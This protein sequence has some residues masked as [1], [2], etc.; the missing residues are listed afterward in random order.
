MTTGCE[1]ESCHHDVNYLVRAFVNR[2]TCVSVV[3][4]ALAAGVSPVLAADIRSHPPMR[5]L[6]AAS[7]RP[8]G[9]GPVRF[10]DSRTGDDRNDGSQSR[11][12]R[13]I[14]YAIEHADPGMTVCLRGGTYYEH[15]TLSLQATRQKPVTLRSHP[16]ELAI[17][18]GGLR[19]FAESP[20]SAWEPVPDGAAGEFRSTQTWPDLGGR[21]GSTNLLGNFGDSMIPLHGYRYIEDLRSDN[22]YLSELKSGKSE[23]G[24]GVYC[25]PGLFYDISTGRIHIRLAHTRQTALGESN[26]RGETDPRRLSLIIAGT[27]PGPALT[28]DGSSFIRIQDLVVRG[29]RSATVQVTDSVNVEFDGVTMYGGAAPISVRDTAG[30][31]LWNCACRGIAAPWTF[32]GSLKYR[33]IEARLFSASGWSPTGRDNRNFELAY[34]EFTDCVDGVFIGNVRSV[35]FHHNL[36]DNVSDD[37]IFLTATTAYDGTTHGGD[38]HIYQNLLSR[39]LTTFA[40]GVGHGRQKMTATGRQ[41]GSGVY[42]YRNVFDLREPVHYQQPA[43]GA[44]AVT[45]AGRIAGDHGSPL[46]EPMRVYHNTILLREPPYRSYYGGGLGGHLA[47]GSTRRVFNNMFV[48]LQGRPG[49]VLPPVIPVSAAR[50]QSGE[51][52]DQNAPRKAQ[53]SRLD[54][55]LDG[56]P[57][58]LRKQPVADSSRPAPSEEVPRTPATDPAAPPAPLPVDFQADGNLHWGYGSAVSAGELFQRFRSS[59]Q[60]ENSRQLYQPGWTAHDIVADP[61]FLAFDATPGGPVDLRPAADSPARDAGVPLDADWPDPLRSRD[62]GQPDIG[63]VPFDGRVWRVGVDGRLDVFGQT[64]DRHASV[65]APGGF[66]PIDDDFPQPRSAGR[67]PVLIM[68]GYPAFDAPLLEFEFRRRGIRFESVEKTWVPPSEYRK[69]AAVIIAGNLLRAGIEPN[70]YSTQ[71]LDHVRSFL[72]AGGTLWLMRGNSWVFRE[73]HGQRFLF[74]LTGGSTGRQTGYRVLAPEHPWLRHLQHPEEADW[75]SPGHAEPIRASAGEA[76]IGND[77]GLTT[78][79]RVD[80]G[81]GQLIYTGWNIAASLPHGRKASTV[82]QEANYEEQMM[83]L[84]NIISSLK[85]D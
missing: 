11:P 77:A 68:Q 37:G 10:V 71:D 15:V 31:R 51:A 27:S 25:G 2:Q 8:P 7:R 12:W 83:V 69:Y 23:A 76:V 64:D 47:G 44:P 78:L 26:Y 20:E 19:Q 79:Y 13:T 5:P 17:I 42:V 84:R 65:A 54:S 66:L 38:I 34:S 46:W 43:A 30:L 85:T 70:R 72:N 33:S 18:D 81:Q 60:F 50:R 75:V 39:C 6:P 48:Q 74:D 36:L 21:P 53:R 29:A 56:D 58:T 4:A 22:E 61:Q 35:R 41:T 1:R 82:R 28:I 73:P 55:L 67:K 59:P 16:G 45:S 62:A 52:R 57:I 14:Q 49:S 24:S 9:D 80:A 32:R 63:A 40:F 3:V